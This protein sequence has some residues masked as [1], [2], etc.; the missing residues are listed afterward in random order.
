MADNRQLTNANENG[1]RF[2]SPLVLNIARNEGISFRNWKR[3]PVQVMK[4]ELLKKIFYQYVTKR[5]KRKWF[6]EPPC[7]G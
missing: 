2:Y 1:N 4:A 6:S 7:C 5:K 3:F